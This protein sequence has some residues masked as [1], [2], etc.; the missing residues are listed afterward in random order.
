M[1]RKKPAKK[2]INT[3]NPDK[4]NRSFKGVWVPAE[5]WCNENL[6]IDERTHEIEKM[7]LIQNTSSCNKKLSPYGY[8]PPDT[9]VGGHIVDEE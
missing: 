2:Q 8:T 4:P 3:L 5:I 9:E 7:F 6:T 1:I